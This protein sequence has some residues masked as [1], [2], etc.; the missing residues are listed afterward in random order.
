MSHETANIEVGLRT[1][2]A[3]FLMIDLSDYEQEHKYGV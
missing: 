3:G 2:L 1:E